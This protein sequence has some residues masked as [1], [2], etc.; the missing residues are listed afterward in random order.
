MGQIYFRFFV[1]VTVWSSCSCSSNFCG[2]Y[3]EE[4]DFCCSS[5]I[6]LNA[7]NLEFRSYFIPI[8]LVEA[9]LCTS[10]SQSHLRSIGFK[11]LNNWLFYFNSITFVSE[12]ISENVG[13]DPEIVFFLYFLKR[14]I[15]SKFSGHFQWSHNTTNKLDCNENQTA[16]RPIK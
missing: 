8:L 14:V 4:S 15:E 5:D 12:H 9:Q 1:S 3:R 6:H 13:K 10:F 7:C 16:E 11:R 2:K